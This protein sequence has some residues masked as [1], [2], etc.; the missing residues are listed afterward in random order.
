MKMINL[1]FEITPIV[2][3]K[4]HV[5]FFHVKQSNFT[6]IKWFL[7][8]TQ[9]KHE[10]I[11]KTRLYRKRYNLE[12]NEDLSLKFVTSILNRFKAIVSN[13]QVFIYLEMTEK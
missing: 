12:S 2:V 1:I 13:F 6:N 7:S 5:T 9:D 8:Y 11:A 4:G 3:P 10:K